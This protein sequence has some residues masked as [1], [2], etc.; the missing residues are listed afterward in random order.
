MKTHN[1]GSQWTQLHVW[2]WNCVIFFYQIS[3]ICTSTCTWQWRHFISS[4]SLCLVLSSSKNRMLSTTEMIGF[5]CSG[6][7]VCWPMLKDIHPAVAF[8]QLSKVDNEWMNEWVSESCN[9]S[10]CLY[11]HLLLQ[12]AFCHCNYCCCCCCVLSF[13]GYFWC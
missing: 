12:R 9:K 2:I 4:G 8:S 11:Q 10:L 13:P 7:S 6:F 3:I 1:L 5:G